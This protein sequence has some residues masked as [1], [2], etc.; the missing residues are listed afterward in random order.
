MSD[1]G[2]QAPGQGRE[3]SDPTAPV[4]E[5]ETYAM[6]LLGMLVVGRAAIR[7]RRR[8]PIQL[9]RGTIDQRGLEHQIF[10]RISDQLQFGIDDQIG[11]GMARAQRDHGVGIGDEIAHILRHL[12]EDDG[13]TVGHAPRV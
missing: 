8:Q 1:S 3:P 9:A 4:P 10:G 13:Q 12:G 2:W 5:P 7:R 6:M 11:M